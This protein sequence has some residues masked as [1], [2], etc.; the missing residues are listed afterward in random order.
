MSAIEDIMSKHQWKPTSYN[1]PRRYD[2]REAMARLEK[3]VEEVLAQLDRE[4]NSNVIMV[5]G[6][7]AFSCSHPILDLWESE[8]EELRLANMTPTEKFIAKRKATGPHWTMK[9]K[10]WPRL[11][12]GPG[13]R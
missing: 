11:R 1:Y 13:R 8:K 5:N 9:N 3:A 7:G 10:A 2:L 6:G 12:V 4:N